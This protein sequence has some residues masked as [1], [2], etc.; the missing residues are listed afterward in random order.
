VYGKRA[1]EV[2][3]NWILVA[4]FCSYRGLKLDLFLGV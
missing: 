3:D 2:W 1:I 4:D